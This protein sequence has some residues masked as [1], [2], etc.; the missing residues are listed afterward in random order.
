MQ[1]KKYTIEKYL[2][3]CNKFNAKEITHTHTH[4]YVNPHIFQKIII[5][6]DSTI[7][8]SMLYKLKCTCEQISQKN[9]LIF[10]NEVD[11]LLDFI[12]ASP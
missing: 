10:D 3:R 11:A 9:I 4:T 7:T 8:M 5:Q 6:I 1:L 12:H 2:M